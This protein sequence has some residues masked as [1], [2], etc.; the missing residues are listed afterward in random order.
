MTTEVKQIKYKQLRMTKSTATILNI[1]TET[2]DKGA[3]RHAAIG[4]I[5]KFGMAL[6]NQEFEDERNHSSDEAYEEY[7]SD[8]KLKYCNQMV[9]IQKPLSEEVYEMIVEAY[10]NEDLH[11]VKKFSM[12]AYVEHSVNLYIEQYLEPAK[13][14]NLLNRVEVILKSKAR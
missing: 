2:V 14:A 13:R 10:E 7:L 11:L 9:A 4:E 8:L 1:L 5:L 6:T 12:R 3:E